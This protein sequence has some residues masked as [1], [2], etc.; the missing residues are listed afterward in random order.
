MVKNDVVLE[1]KELSVAYGKRTLL[2]D[3]N[4]EVRAGEF[5]FFLGPN[6]V[7]KTTLLKVVLGMMRPQGGRVFSHPEFANRNSIGFVP[8]RCD[9]NPTLP[10][11]VSEFVLMGLAGI[12][13]DKNGRYERLSM[14]LDKMD[15]KDMGKKSYWAL[16]G[17]Q[18][19]RALIARALVRRPKFLIADEPT[20]DLDLST[21]NGLM[22]ALTDLNR[23]ENLTIIFVTHDLTLAARYCTHTALFIDGLVRT[24]A[25][26]VILNAEDIEKA[27]GVPVGICREEETAGSFTLRINRRGG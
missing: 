20:K 15:L 18:R 21:A 16:S 19:Q 9:L 3:I 1:M 14:A 17:G 13:T 11:T 27:Y 5:W 26:H 2:K 4:L 24:G 23:K 22:E 12:R 7:G 8:Q 25:C 6:G 10:T